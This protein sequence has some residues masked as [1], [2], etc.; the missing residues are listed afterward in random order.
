MFFFVNMDDL[1][2]IRAALFMHFLRKLVNDD[3]GRNGSVQGFGKPVQR[4]AVRAYRAR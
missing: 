1:C 2:R 4:Q 3:S